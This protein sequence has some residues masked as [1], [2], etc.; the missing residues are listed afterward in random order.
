MKYSIVT[1]SR[2]TATARHSEAWDFTAVIKG[3]S[4]PCE[5][6]RGNSQL[7]SYCWCLALQSKRFILCICWN[8]SFLK[9][10]LTFYH[11][12]M[13]PNCSYTKRGGI[14]LYFFLQWLGARNSF[15]LWYERWEVRSL[16]PFRPGRG[17]GWVSLSELIT[18]Y[19]CIVL[20]FFWLL[21]VKTTGGIEETEEIGPFLTCSLDHLIAMHSIHDFLWSKQ[22]YD[23]NL[24]FRLT[25]H[26]NFGLE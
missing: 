15:L 18:V 16:L 20:F 4:V 25:P 2:S 9:S 14:K 8:V 10:K 26:T 13:L 22:V 1:L 23:C 19:I 21:K 5:E 11:C 12:Y 3:F 24:H 7:E 17:Q 6:R